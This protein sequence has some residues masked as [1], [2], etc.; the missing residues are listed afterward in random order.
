VARIETWFLGS[1]RP[2]LGTNQPLETAKNQVSDSKHDDIPQHC[3][4]FDSSY[5][6]IDLLQGVAAADQLI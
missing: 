3:P 4:G 5:C 2:L 6:F 1:K